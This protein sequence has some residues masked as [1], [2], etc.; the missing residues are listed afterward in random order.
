MRTFYRKF[1]GKSEENQQR[2]SRYFSQWNSAL[3]SDAEKRTHTY[4]DC[5]QCAWKH[6]T[7]FQLKTTNEPLVKQVMTEHYRIT[8]NQGAVPNSIPPLPVPPNPSK[9]N[10]SNSMAQIEMGTQTVSAAPLDLE[11][12]TA[13]ENNLPLPPPPQ[14]PGSPAVP[15]IKQRR[16]IEKACVKRQIEQSKPGQLHS[17]F[18]NNISTRKWDRTRRENGEYVKNP[19]KSHT[20]QID[21]YTL[22]INL[23]KSLLGEH[24]HLDDAMEGHWT[25]LAK[26]V[27]LRNRK[28]QPAAEFNAGQVC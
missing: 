2:Y 10:S 15:D 4:R 18:V 16:C 24:L 19:E 3:L 14:R 25:E 22:D 5:R 17:M 27:N 12:D 21:S 20:S 8:L 26:K 28:G 13:A 1:F 7:I 11:D 9:E 6:R 23:A